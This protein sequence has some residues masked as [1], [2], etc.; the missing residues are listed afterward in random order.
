MPGIR[1]ARLWALGPLF[2][3]ALCPS[4][5]AGDLRLV[6]VSGGLHKP[7]FAVS[8][9]EDY[10]RLFV[11]EQGGAVRI[12]RRGALVDTPFLQ[13][14]D[15]FPGSDGGVLGVAF[16]PSYRYNGR[17]FCYY[18]RATA[19]GEVELAIV[20]YRRSAAEDDRADPNGRLVFRARMVE[21]THPGGKLR[22]GPDGMLYA[23]TGDGRPA[24][25]TSQEPGPALDLGS[26]FGKI[27]RFD[28]DR[29]FPHVPQ[30]PDANPWSGVPGAQHVWAVGLRNPYG[31]DFDPETGDLWISDVGEC[32]QEEVDRVPFA[33]AR[34]ASFGWGCVEGAFVHIAPCPDPSGAP[35]I[36]PLHTYPHGLACSSTTVR[37]A[38]IGG[39]LYRGRAMPWLHGQYF[40]GDFG[41]AEVSSIDASGLVTDWT[42]DLGTCGGMPPLIG[43]FDLTG[44]GTDAAGEL[45]LM[46]WNLD[47]ADGQIWRIAPGCAGAHFCATSGVDVGL[48]STGESARLC[49]NGSLAVAEND[50]YLYVERLPEHQVGY[51]LASRT[52]AGPL[53]LGSGFLCLGA[54]LKRFAG[55]LQDTGALRTITFAPDLSAFPGGAA[56]LAGDSWNFQ[57]WYRDVLAGAPTT[58]FSDAAALTFR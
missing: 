2:V 20:E 15:V 1:S 10:D 43:A 33:D 48:N 13:L 14:P 18:T 53:P 37:V 56:V 30:E 51:F 3:A 47:G 6:R 5:A 24:Q 52:T 23:S 27:L 22:F 35:P 44:F 31:F 50:L 54:P 8:P 12:L 16:H 45:Y 46:D 4:A 58:N 38:V 40:F 39:S 57:L 41:S 29:P 25:C 34:G 17:L 32:L 55:S 7:M 11:A 42:Q 21:P 9:P 28:V 36:P 19:G 26:P 49:A